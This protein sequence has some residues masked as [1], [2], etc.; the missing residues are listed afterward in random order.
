M[1]RSLT[2]SAV[3]TCATSS[4]SI[5]RATLSLPTP[6]WHRVRYN[7]IHVSNGHSDRHGD[8]HVQCP[9]TP[10]GGSP[11]VPQGPPGPVGLHCSQIDCQVETDCRKKADC[12][13]EGTVGY[14]KAGEPQREGQPCND[15]DPD[16][17]PDICRSG[18]C[19]GL[20]PPSECDC[21]QAINNIRSVNLACVS[22]RCT[23]AS[24][25]EKSECARLPTAEGEPC[26]DGNSDTT[27]DVCKDMACKGKDPCLE[28]KP[29]NELNLPECVKYHECN[30][31]MGEKHGVWYALNPSNNDVKCGNDT[32]VI[33]DT[34]Q[35][36]C[37]NNQCKHFIRMRIARLY[38]YDQDKT[39]YLGGDAIDFMRNPYGRVPRDIHNLIA[40]TE[41]SA[42]RDNQVFFA[43]NRV[44]VVTAADVA[45]LLQD[46]NDTSKSGDK[47]LHLDRLTSSGENAGSGGQLIYRFHE[48]QKVVKYALVT[49]P[50]AAQ[51]PISWVVDAC[52]D[53]QTDGNSSTSGVT[54]PSGWK[55]V[56]RS[57]N[58]TKG[59]DDRR[60]NTSYH[61]L[62]FPVPKYSQRKYHCYRFKPNK[63][64]G[65][66]QTCDS[67][68]EVLRITVTTVGAV[69]ILVFVVYGFGIGIGYRMGKARVSGDPP[70]LTGETLGVV[71]DKCARLFYPLI[72]MWH[73]Q[74]EAT[75][76]DEAVDRLFAPVGTNPLHRLGSMLKQ[77]WYQS[78]RQPES[79][80]HEFPSMA[81]L[82]MRLYSADPQDI[83]R[84]MGYPDAPLATALSWGHNTARY[85]PGEAKI[86][87]SNYK[88][89]CLLET[90]ADLELYGGK[91]NSRN[92]CHYS[93][94][95]VLC[96]EWAKTEGWRAMQHLVGGTFF[97]DDRR[98]KMPGWI[99]YCSLLYWLASETNVHVDPH[100]PSEALLV[101][102]I[103]PDSAA[104]REFRK[105]QVG[106]WYATP[107]LSSTSRDEKAQG[108][109]MG[110][111]PGDAIVLRFR[112]GYKVHGIS[113][114]EISFYPEEKEVLLAPGTVCK[115]RKRQWV[116]RVWR[117]VTDTTCLHFLRAVYRPLLVLDLDYVG[118]LAEQNHECGK[119]VRDWFAEIRSDALLA[120]SVLAEAPAAPSPEDD[121][122]RVVRGVIMSPRL[123]LGGSAKASAVK[124][125]HGHVDPAD[126]NDSLS[127]SSGSSTQEEDEADLRARVPTVATVGL[128]AARQSVWCRRGSTPPSNPVSPAHQ[129][130]RAGPAPPTIV[131]HLALRSP[132]PSVQ[133]GGDQFT[134]GGLDPPD[135][136]TTGV[137]H[138]STQPASEQLDPDLMAPAAVTAR[139]SSSAGSVQMAFPVEVLH[140]APD[141][142]PSSSLPRAH[143]APWS[144]G[145]CSPISPR[146]SPHIGG[147][148]RTEWVRGAAGPPAPPPG[149]LPPPPP[150]APPPPPPDPPPPVPEGPVPRRLLRK[151]SMLTQAAPPGPGGD[152]TDGGEPEG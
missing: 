59:L 25:K 133:R 26:D 149:C 2:R 138:L 64:R 118:P 24:N 103:R 3:R 152:P 94:P 27:R 142:S 76:L 4:T 146:S 119:R 44:A 79:S 122:S 150:G 31:Q 106:H 74:S 5:Q 145:R 128:F 130:F 47:P 9:V 143:G 129:R 22:L 131:G 136:F 117:Y 87:W 114:K 137:P 141:H 33:T 126:D 7:H 54:C 45:K 60:W 101:R 127:S 29:A 77:P 46:D 110:A 88:S 97:R 120:S 10:G 12:V 20:P 72:E 48:M 57:E 56:H 63:L 67:G 14:C 95:N 105:L 140:S 83:D 11:S 112:C 49:G 55:L 134:D 42:V 66:C 50:T 116:R 43:D 121:L 107:A 148:R 104:A 98:T 108:R 32:A 1:E 70:P 80:L 85:K 30:R 38:F 15:S 13:M 41:P 40:K 139:A 36:F 34:T 132:A 81:L 109:F 51:D 8:F 99:K 53:C 123:R 90:E 23:A 58:D 113:L 89:K 71:C 35:Q 65:G 39:E 28:N 96:R 115:V 147:P 93:I 91:R 135:Q 111:H 17:H 61:Q 6:D 18:V 37:D 124:G 78:C 102:I 82:A 151:Q 21:A 144:E 75:V 62:S 84:E 19:I 125:I 68:P 16:T 73:Q 100:S 86:P 69:F 92:Y 52:K